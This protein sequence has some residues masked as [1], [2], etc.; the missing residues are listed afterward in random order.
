[1]TPR[2]RRVLSVDPA[3][4]FRLLCQQRGLP[5]PVAEH[6]F[7]ERED[8]RRWKFDFAFVEEKV[9]LEVEGGVW[10]N[11]RHNRG[12]G[13]IN[14]M[15]KY[16]EAAAQGWLVLRVLPKDLYSEATLQL[17]QRTLAVAA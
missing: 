12:K 1:V 2:A 16:S 15:E 9:A 3:V 17:V 6:R 14:D 13:F 11:G 8:A 10:V 5:L 4:A 7:D